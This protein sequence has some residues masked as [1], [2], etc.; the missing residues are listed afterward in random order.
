ME[1]NKRTILIITGVFL[2]V[3]FVVWLALQITHPKSSPKAI[4][5][6]VVTSKTVDPATIGANPLTFEN[7]TVETEGDISDWLT[8][9]SFSLGGGGSFSNGN[10]IIVINKNTFPSPS[11][12]S[13]GQ[14]ALGQNVKVHIKG[15]VVVLNREQLGKELGIDMDSQKTQLEPTLYGWQLGVVILSESVQKL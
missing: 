4:V 9:K 10:P 7:A 1:L 2:F 5:S 12:A 8:S 14:L 11:S 6:Q 13:D 15:K 3:L